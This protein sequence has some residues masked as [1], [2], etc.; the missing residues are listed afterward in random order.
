MNTLR[1]LVLFT[2]LFSGCA[3]T[4]AGTTPVTPTDGVDG[5]QYEGADAAHGEG[6]TTASDASE[7]ADGAVTD[8]TDAADATDSGDG[9]DGADAASTEPATLQLVNL[10]TG[11]VALDVRS[12]DETLAPALG[13]ANGTAPI[14]VSHPADLAWTV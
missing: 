1:S 7:A 13:F 11:S 8:A 14:V 9:A 4:D 5:G 10:V 2:V 6:D 12:G 3:G